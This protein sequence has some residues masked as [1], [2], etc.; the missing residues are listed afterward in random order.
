MRY[1]SALIVSALVASAPLAAKDNVP[2]Y[3]AEL[4]APTAKQIIA[5]GVLWMC[6]G[7]LCF[8]GRGTARP[9]VVC[10]R[11]AQASSPVVTFSYGTTAL[12]A[13]ELARC[14]G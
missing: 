8:A 3:R 4:S 13:S 5:G 1:V 6:E 12:G 14:N 9:E 11:L 7:T 10:K 2:Y